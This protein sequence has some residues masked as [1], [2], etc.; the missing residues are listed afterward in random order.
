MFDYG[1]SDKIIKGASKSHVSK[2]K[3]SLR[4]ATES[5]LEEQPE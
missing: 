4:E 2:L 3:A 1:T 5:A